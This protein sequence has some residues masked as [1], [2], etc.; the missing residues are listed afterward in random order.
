MPFDS[1]FLVPDAAGR[2]L[3]LLPDGAAWRLP[4]WPVAEAP[5]ERDPGFP[6][7]I[8]AWVREHIGVD[9]V[10]LHWRNVEA[11]ESA[12]APAR[13]T[14]YVLESQA[15]PTPPPGA[16]WVGRA[17]LAGLPLAEPYHRPVLEAWFAEA[18]GG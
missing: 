8:R 2:H 13:Q 3:L 15:P 18:A 16:R 9:A 4:R 6:V 10:V 17:E 14:V 11:P 1:H 7:P 12:G 5:P